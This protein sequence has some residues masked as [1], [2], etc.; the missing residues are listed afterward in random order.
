MNSKVRRR[1]S[2][3]LAITLANTSALSAEQIIPPGSFSEYRSDWYNSVL[4]AMDEPPLLSDGSTKVRFLWAP[5][6]NNY[7][8]VSVTLGEISSVR[9]RQVENL[10]GLEGPGRLIASHERP[11]NSNEIE[12]VLRRVAFL[13]TCVRPPGKQGYDGSQWV[14]EFR[15]KDTHCAVDQWY[16]R[17]GTWRKLGLFL[18]RLGGVEPCRMFRCSEVEK[19]DMLR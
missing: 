14:F 13:E 12:E 16:P 6:F 17:S 8:A 10:G 15:D 2:V 1:L 11:L 4:E 9:M 19:R 18:F 5:A 7:Y 3:V